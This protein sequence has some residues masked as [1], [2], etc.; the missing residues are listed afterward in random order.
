VSYFGENPQLWQKVYQSVVQKLD[1]LSRRTDGR[2]PHSPPRS[3]NSLR[4]LD[5]K[6]E[7]N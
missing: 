5:E 7:Q 6:A 3:N 4:S 2:F 1:S